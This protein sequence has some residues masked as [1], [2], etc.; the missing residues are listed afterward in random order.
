V[1]EDVE[2]AETTANIAVP[3]IATANII[4]IIMNPRWDRTPPT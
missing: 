1:R 2:N 3:T 4:S